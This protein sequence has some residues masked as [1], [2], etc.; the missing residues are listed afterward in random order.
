ML[1][2]VAAFATFL[3][4]PDSSPILKILV[5]IMLVWE[6]WGLY[7][8]LKLLFGKEIINVCTDSLRIDKRIIWFS[9][10]QEYPSEFVR[11]LRVLPNPYS[12]EYRTWHRA[13]IW[14]DKGDGVI[15]FKAGSQ[16]VRFGSWLDESEAQEIVS[17]IQMGLQKYNNEKVSI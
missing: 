15:Y 17:V 7:Y 13:E 16:D 5:A 12:S 6:V 4:K 9:Q 10:S 14:W 11:E 3:L 1:V 8:L 2:F